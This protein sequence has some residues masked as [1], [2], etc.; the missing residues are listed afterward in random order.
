MKKI[1]FKNFS[2][3]IEFYAYMKHFLRVSHKIEEIHDAMLQTGCMMAKANEGL[4][5]NQDQKSIILG[6]I[7]RLFDEESEEV[8]E[9][10]PF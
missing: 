1:K 5:Y 3:G 4:K 9:E 6:K 7:K 10:M 8:E 2:A